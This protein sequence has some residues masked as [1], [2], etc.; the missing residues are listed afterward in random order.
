MPKNLKGG[1]GAKKGKNKPDMDAN[2]NRPMPLKDEDYGAD[3]DYAVVTKRLGNGQLLSTLC[4]DGREV[5]ALMRGAFKSKKFRAQRIRFEI[6]SIMMIAH[7]D[8][9]R[10]WKERQYRRDDPGQKKEQVQIIHLYTREQSR[11][12]LRMGEIPK[13]MVLTNEEEKEQNED[14]DT[15]FIIENGGVGDEQELDIDDI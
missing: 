6:G 15:G 13:W 7:N 11:K 2:K 4:D 10:M 14:D 1:K 12:L 8:W 5:I 9:D 3:V